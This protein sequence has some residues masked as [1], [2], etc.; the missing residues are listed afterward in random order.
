MIRA[1]LAANA[2]LNLK[3]VNGITAL[4]LASTNGHF[5]PVQALLDKGGL[6]SMPQWP[7][8]RPR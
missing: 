7:M 6:T 8:A 3:S 2:D 1:L 4:I 5:G